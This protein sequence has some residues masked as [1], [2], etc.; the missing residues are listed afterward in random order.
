MA[1]AIP[2]KQALFW[3]NVYLEL[4][5]V[6]Q[7]ALRRMRGLIATGSTGWSVHRAD[8]QLI[9]AEIT[10]VIDRLRYWEDQVD[11]AHRGPLGK[12]G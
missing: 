4:L 11:R 5:A 9:T 3:M 8:I 12:L 7:R 10:R 2:L 6:D 1:E